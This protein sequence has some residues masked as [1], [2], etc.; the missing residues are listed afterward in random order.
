MIVEIVAAGA[1]ALGLRALAHRAI[2]RGLRAPRLQ[3]WHGQG[4]PDASVGAVREVR[5]DGQRGRRLWGAL[6][7]PRHFATWPVPAVLV[8]HGWGANAATM[9][10][11]VAPLQAAGFA[12]LLIDARCH[13]RSDDEDF[14]SLPR[15][16]EDI[17]AGL[18]WLRRQPG[19]D[20]DRLALL[21]HSVGAGAALL[22][23]ARHDDVR[24]VV[25]LSAFA[26]PR[27][28]MRRFMRDKRVPYPVL[29]WYVMRHVQRVIGHSFDEIAP[30]TTLARVRCPVLLVH[31]RHDA[32][33]PFGDAQRLKSV[34]PR[35]RLLAVDGDHDLREAL[36][37]HVAEVT[38]FLWAACG[39]PAAADTP[40]VD[41]DA[42]STDGPHASGHSEMVPAKSV[43]HSAESA[44]NG[45]WSAD[46]AAAPTGKASGY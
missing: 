42:G 39:E 41:V 14:T 20:S 15:F 17:A 8:M 22:H 37:P 29:G 45:L 26:H 34:S 2:L 18:A 30:L 12:V 33:V 11:V 9:A 3:H 28:M 5:I 35:A 25:S 31:G 7:M 32:T 27:E 4:E 36:L 23:A 1:A 24:A 44:A 43:P 10:P 21:G 16:A 38:D 13:G 19:I 40:A 46:P 6:V